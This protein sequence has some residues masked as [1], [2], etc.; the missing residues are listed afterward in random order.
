[1]L[2]DDDDELGLEFEQEEDDGFP[3]P[4]TLSGPSGEVFFYPDL[5][6]SASSTRPRLCRSART[7]GFGCTR[8]LA[9]S[10]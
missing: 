1:M 7:A 5:A 10:R 3:Y 9:V 6:R 4:D 2:P 8:R